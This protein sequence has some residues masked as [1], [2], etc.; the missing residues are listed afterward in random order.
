M[1]ERN[2]TALLVVGA[3][4]A[5]L[6]IF[7]KSATVAP[8]GAGIGLAA[9]TSPSGSLS[10]ILTP[11]E[12]GAA[13]ALSG[14]E[15]FDNFGTYETAPDNIPVEG[16]TSAISPGIQTSTD[17]GLSTTLSEPSSL[18]SA[19]DYNGSIDDWSD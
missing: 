10:G 19:D 13:S 7:R 11:V 18:S 12:E 15:A 6:L 16:I 2:T 1:A 5:G 3:V 9:T 17:Y 4:V 14:L 8:S